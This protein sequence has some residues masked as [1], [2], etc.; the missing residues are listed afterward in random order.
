MIYTGSIVQLAQNALKLAN[1][2]LV[3]VLPVQVLTN[4]DKTKSK[5]KLC[6]GNNIY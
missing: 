6:T 4:P 1:N 5:A 2:I 3:P